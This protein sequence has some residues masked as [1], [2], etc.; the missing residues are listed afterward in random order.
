MEEN[1]DSPSKKPCTPYR[2]P[3]AVL[4]DED[5]EMSNEEEEPKVN[6]PAE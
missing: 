6:S 3:S 4:P 1:A 5:E 2:I